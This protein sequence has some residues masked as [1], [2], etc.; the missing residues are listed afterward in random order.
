MKSSS[1]HFA[2]GTPLPLRWLYRC[3]RRIIRYT[4]Q[5]YFRRTT[6]IGA[7][8]LQFDGPAILVSN[9]PNTLLDPYILGAYSYPFL[10]FLA[11]A[12]LW[13][14]LPGRLFFGTF[15]IPL[16][17][18][19]DKGV[20][21]IDNDNSFEA[22]SAHLRG[23]GVLYV[24]PEGTSELERR[25]RPI[26]TGTARIILQTLKD[27]NFQLPVKLAHA[28]LTY[29]DP[30]RFQSQMWIHAAPIVIPQI[31]AEAYRDNYRGLV[32]ELTEN[33]QTQLEALTL[34]TRDDAEDALLR[35][36]ETLLRHEQPLSGPDEFYRSRDLLAS[37]Q[38]LSVTDYEQLRLDTDA[39]FAGLEAHRL[40]DRLFADGYRISVLGLPLYLYGLI[41]N[42]LP[43]AV[44]DTVAHN[45]IDEDA[46]RSAARWT[47]G[48][49]FI[50][51][52]YGLQTTVVQAT[53][54][55]WWVSLLYFLTLVPSGLFAY[56]YHQ[57][58]AVLAER[59]RY[60][61]LT[62]TLR[63]TLAEQRERILS[64]IAPL[65]AATVEA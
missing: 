51:L 19:M 60:H 48:L 6:V 49:V 13:K 12:S 58:L 25:I 4:T 27:S 55:R 30:T 8:H 38:R 29:S 33:I 47:S 16:A 65:I 52:F 34:V 14:S 64:Q 61:Q 22:A 57:R 39:Y 17:R 63:T 37:L 53:F 9:H 1:K 42:V 3:L 41:N 36:L 23:G 20:P 21:G 54:G 56:R 7:E 44:V 50:P 46:F 2:P 43:A 11:K 18:R 59:F 24:A 45:I 28:G 62:A 31:T 32:D 10:Y 40:S 15:C 35:R 26:K 5:L